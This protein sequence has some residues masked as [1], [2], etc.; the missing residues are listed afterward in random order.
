MTADRQWDWD[1]TRFDSPLGL[2]W[3]TALKYEW[4]SEIYHHPIVHLI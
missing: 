3:A 4:D 1:G 2:A